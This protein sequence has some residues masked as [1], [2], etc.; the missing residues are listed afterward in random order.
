MSDFPSNR[1]STTVTSTVV[2]VI[3]SRYIG[4]LLF[5]GIMLAKLLFLHSGLHAPNIDM[6][7]QD[8]W[9]A[10]GSVMLL[11]FW[12]LWLPRRGQTIAL[13][14]INLLLTLLIYSDIVYYRYFQDFITVPVLFQAGQMDALG[15]S[16]FA[17]L[18]PSDLYLFADWLLFIAYGI[19]TGFYHQKTH[20]YLSNA[21]PRR[22]GQSHSYSQTGYSRRS[23]RLSRMLKRSVNGIVALALGC[24]LTFG[25]IHTYATTWAKD[26]FTGNWWSL[27]MYNVTGLI[28]FHGYDIYLY[29]KDHLGP[30]P[31]LSQEEAT[32]MQLWF[33]K[34][35]TEQNANNDSFGKYSGSNIVVI[36]AEAFMNFVVGRSIS[37][38][39]I[40]PNLN[41]L[42]KEN[43]YF[44]NYYHQTS[45]GRTSDADFTS[46]ASLYPLVSGSV[47]V[48]YPDHQFHTLPAILKSKDYSTN[49]FHAY[50]GSFWNRQIM[51]NAMGYDHFYNKK[52]YTIDEPL[53]WSLGDKSFLRQ[54]LDI[55]DTSE[56]IKQPFY[57]FLTTLSSH[58]PYS[59]PADKQGLDTGEFKGTIFGDYLQAVHYTD[60]ALG[61]M[62]KEM[63][64]RG[65][66]DNTIVAF[67]GDHDNSIQETSYYE[68]F[69]GK[70]LSAL[71]MQQIMHQVPLLIH[72][73]GSNASVLDSAPAGQLDL[74]PSLLHLLGISRDPYYLM[75]N[76][77]FS[78][79]E[80]LVTLRSGAYADAKLSYLPSENGQFASGTCYS[81]E[82]REA[83][84]V[85]ECSIGYETSKLR[86]QISDD[87]MKYDGIK[88]LKNTQSAP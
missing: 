46:N 81:L 45:Q 42:I 1:S 39:E 84:D 50:E 32:S 30:Q 78:G 43:T 15:G 82:S 88:K 54:S 8:K 61:E 73:P 19:G 76:N 56:T 33:N 18:R 2:A 74:T 9:I 70:S 49:A 52:D 83:V 35:N 21:A 67:Y 28:G 69:L 7:R 12:T 87:I 25:P 75:G 79:H 41:A 80:R 57:S 77:L 4:Y 6:N 40:T 11:S 65:L 37:G 71:D 85:G 5:L 34:Q 13:L 31:E 36:Q 17:L 60:E 86:L 29:A 51:Y 59:L 22:Y 23:S 72:L 58:H 14:S 26:L 44:S 64:Q 62:V 10:V 3:R 20:T 68:Q 66:W 63:K 53:G 27:A 16:I 38:Q 24:V 47:F 48:R 55:M